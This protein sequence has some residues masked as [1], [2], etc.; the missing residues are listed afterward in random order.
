VNL[1]YPYVIINE[2]S[3]MTSEVFITGATGF[4]G[5]HLVDALIE[6]G[7]IVNCLVRKKSNLKWLEGKPV[8]IVYHDSENAT[9]YSVIESALKRSKYIYHVAGKISAISREDFMKGNAGLTRWLIERIFNSGAKP[10][11]FLLVSSIAACGPGK[12]TLPVQESQEPNPVSAYGESKLAQEKI[13][14]EFSREIPVTIV[15]PPPVYGP[16]DIGML[17]A[18]KALKIGII[19]KWGKGIKT[20]FVFV[21]DLVDGIIMAAENKSSAG[22]I[23]NIAG[24][25]NLPAHEALEKIARSAGKRVFKVTIPV[26]LMWT[27]AILTE[28]K[29]KISRR[30]SIFN[31]E[32]M[33]EFKEENWTVDIT[34]AKNDLGYEPRIGLEEGGLITWKWYIENGWI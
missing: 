4:V 13:A 20:N 12:G 22:E 30:P 18:I 2:Y 16:R 26:P 24:S 29:I 31:L 23:Y 5:S 33:K 27:L 21:S 6:R 7:Y 34:K 19:P 8:K 1:N 17:P 28:F 9:T 14:L 11:R 32:K 25:E 10:E 15:R 3:F